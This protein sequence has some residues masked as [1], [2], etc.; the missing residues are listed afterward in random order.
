MQVVDEPGGEELTQHR[1]AASDADV[2]TRGRLPSGV[3][4]L[5]R[6]GVEEVERRTAVHLQWRARAMGQDVRWRVERRI[7]APPSAPLRVVLPTR[8]AELAGAHDLRA[9]AVLVTLGEGVVDAGS[10]GSVTTQLD[11]SEVIP[12][13]GRD[14][15]SWSR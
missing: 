14:I 1:R 13:S 10:A 8:G 9:D 11:E 6:R 7:V 5:R 2:L 4:C 3:E 12:E 15:H